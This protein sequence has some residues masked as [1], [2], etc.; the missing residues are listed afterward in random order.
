MKSL[1]NAGSFCLSVEK[2]GRLPSLPSEIF[3]S[4]IS[5]ALWFVECLIAILQGR[6]LKDTGNQFNNHAYHYIHQ[7]AP[8][9]IQYLVV[10]NRDAESGGKI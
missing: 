2:E 10:W 6:G 1:S 3:W 7:I 8:V 5:V 4:G 9:H